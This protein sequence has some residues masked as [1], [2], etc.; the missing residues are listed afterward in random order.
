MK[1][2]SIIILIIGTLL[3]QACKPATETYPSG[4]DSNI[5]T[6][7]DPVKLLFPGNWADPTLTRVGDVYYLTS[8]NDRYVPSVLVFQSTD[9]RNWNPI[10]YASPL[11]AQGPATDIVAFGDR[12][13]IYGGGGMGAWVMYADPPYMV[14]S[15]RFNMHPIE[16]HPIDAGHIADT[17]GNRFLYTA[18]GKVVK[19]S[20]D[21]LTALTPPEKVYDAWE[22]P[23][24]I[25]IECVC[26]EAPKLFH[27][28]D[29]YYMV[30]A[31]GGTAGPATSH[32]AIIAR[33]KEPLGPWEDSPY[34]PL[35]WTRDVSE[36]WWSK[37]HATLIEGPS[38]DWFAIYHGYR[39]GYRSFGRET[40]I[41]PVEWTDDDWPMIASEWPEGWDET[42]SV[43]LQQSDEFDGSEIAMQWQAYGRLD[44]ERYNLKD[45]GL[46]ISG[47][48]EEA[49]M[50]NPFT[51]N[52][53]DLAY[54][55]E[56]EIVIEGDVDAGLILFYNNSAW[57]SV[58]L[59]SEGVVFR[60]KR[61]SR[62]R[63]DQRYI[64]DNIPY[65]EKRISL[66]ITND[67][68][69]VAYYYK[70]VEGNWIKFM[71]SDDISGFQHNIFGSFSSVRPGVFVSGKGKARFE[72]FRYNAL[73]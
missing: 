66:K 49:G 42:P 70:D 4:D 3:M 6:K 23:D 60:E 72:Y 40:L 37:G 57:V 32:M 56:T 52:P 45:G 67:R 30:S 44:M 8:N 7:Q 64:Q 12:L 58:G 15:E 10:S 50:S 54:E 69:D 5:I 27:F 28:N 59:S 29:W 17:N 46:E 31:A 33:A 39:N 11:E 71:R 68:Q 73:P 22:I 53:A 20:Q 2:T 21:G 26:L 24:Y 55:V 61:R 34:N 43:N 41:S 38:G 14:W 25:D 13:F 9:L 48:E 19:L 51:I 47:V 36:S 65:S 63:T 1:A 62:D 35:I 16:R 18:Q